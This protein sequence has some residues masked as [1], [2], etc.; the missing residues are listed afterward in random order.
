MNKQTYPIPEGC[1]AI[2]MEIIDN[3]IVT[4]FEPQ[5]KR[6]DVL[7][8]QNKDIFILDKVLNNVYYY[9]I[10]YF[11]FKDEEDSCIIFMNYINHPDY[12][13]S[14]RHATPEEAQR[15]WDALAKEGKRWNPE[16]MQVEEIKKEVQ[17]AKKGD[18]YWYFGNRFGIFNSTENGDNVDDAR[19]D[20][21]NYFLTKEQAQRAA[22]KLKQ[23]LADFWE[24]ELK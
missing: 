15:L 24:E 22:E 16:T 17:R 11:E 14:I 13:K 18:T 5:F 8:G 23:A 9:F 20:F 3:T 1:K 10:A 2:T 12:L 21:G 19:Y 4:T 7:I 6:G